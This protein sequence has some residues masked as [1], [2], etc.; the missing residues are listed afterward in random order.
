MMPCH[1]CAG[2]HNEA[3]WAHLSAGTSR[4]PIVSFSTLTA[5][6]EAVDNALDPAQSLRIF[7]ACL[8]TSLDCLHDKRCRAVQTHCLQQ[9][10]DVQQAIPACAKAGSRPCRPT[11]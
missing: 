10:R 9:S 4:E 7:I 8:S 5:D 6:F 1:T 2:A 3:S 11:E